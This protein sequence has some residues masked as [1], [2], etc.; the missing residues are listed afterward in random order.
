MGDD[1]RA[2]LMNREV[3]ALDQDATGH[4]GDRVYTEG[5]LEV[6]SKPLANGDLAVGV[7]S[8]WRMPLTLDVPLE[9]LGLQSGVA[10][11]VRDLWKHEDLAPLHDSI[12]VQLPVHGVVLLRLH[13]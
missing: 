7:F 3:I 11:S 12:H 1:T 2:I 13:K 4:Q 6:W 9:R 5:P 8:R 10:V